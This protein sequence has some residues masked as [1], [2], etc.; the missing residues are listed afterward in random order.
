M[1]LVAM[2]SRR[3]DLQS[4][5]TKHVLGYEEGMYLTYGN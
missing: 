1:D 4:M 5:G 2:N 3:P